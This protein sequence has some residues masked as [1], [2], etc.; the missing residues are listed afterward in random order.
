VYGVCAKNLV[1]GFWKEFVLRRFVKIKSKQK[2][3]SMRN[4]NFVSLSKKVLA[5][6]PVLVFLSQ[7]GFAQNV[8]TTPGNV[9]AGAVPY[10]TTTGSAVVANSAITQYN[11]SSLGIF[12]VT[13]QQPLHVVGKARFDLSTGAGTIGR[14]YINRGSTTSQENLLQFTTGGTTTTYDW[15][16]GTVSNSSD[17]YFGG[18]VGRIFTA[19]ASNGNVAIGNVANPQTRLQVAGDLLVSAA[20]TSPQSAALI[21]YNSSYSGATNPDYGWSGDAGAGLF[22]P[23]AKVIGFSVNNTEAMRIG[24]GTN[25]YIGIGNLSPQFPLDVNVVNGTALLRSGNA[26]TNL[27]MGYNG[28]GNVIESAGSNLLIN[29]GTGKN[30][31]IGTGGNGGNL[32]IGVPSPDGATILQVGD[33]ISFH[34]GGSKYIGYNCHYTGTGGNYSLVNDYSSALVLAGGN[35]TFQVYG[36]TTRPANTSLDGSVIKAMT[37]MNDGKVHI[38]PHNP[39]SGQHD[40]AELSVYGGITT[41]A[42]YVTDP[43]LSANKWADFVFDKDYKLMSLDDLEKYYKNNHHLPNVPTTKEVEKNGLD[44][45]STE[46]LLLR[47]VEEL[48]LYI[49]QQQKEIE[50]LKAEVKIKK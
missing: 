19:V 11:S 39:T 29:Y 15:I 50:A 46:A 27:I 48:T 26:T 34:N 40:D 4:S 32:G 21:K 36:N 33:R 3:K 24:N 9:T 44:I 42:I 6:L 10:F 8:T 30:V 47:K 38:G 22:H 31:E 25:P 2:I 12:T 49:V 7:N 16:M 14:M 20:T 45:A 5:L 41:T 35:F 23:S 18:S 28:S 17:W 43:N 37:I 1:W 13:P